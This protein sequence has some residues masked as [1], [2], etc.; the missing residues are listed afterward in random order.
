MV[1]GISGLALA[2]DSISCPLD[3]H[4]TRDDLAFAVTRNALGDSDGFT[5]AVFNHSSRIAVDAMGRVLVMS[6]DDY[7]G[8]ASLVAQ[9]ETLPISNMFWAVKHVISCRP[10]DI[11]LIGKDLRRIGV[12]GFSEHMRRLERPVSGLTE[13]PT[14]LW[15]L[16]DL[17][18]EGRE[19]Y[20]R[21]K[22]DMDTVNKVREILKES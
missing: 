13:L 5:L 1:F 7:E 17:V 10:N 3:L 11:L 2:C 19:D 21:G 15:E 14:L 12:H 4:P 6:D 8:L 16:F 20:E 22:G 18:L 9:T